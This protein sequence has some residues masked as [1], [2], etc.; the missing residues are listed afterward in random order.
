MVVKIE[1][2]LKIVEV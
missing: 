2:P 1:I